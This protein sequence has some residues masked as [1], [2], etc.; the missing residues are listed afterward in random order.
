M[1]KSITKT[2]TLAD[3]ATEALNNSVAFAN[4]VDATNAMQK[5]RMS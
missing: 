5:I 3:V 2:T 1:T 4:L